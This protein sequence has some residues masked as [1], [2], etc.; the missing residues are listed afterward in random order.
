MK[1][2]LSHTL[3]KQVRDAGILRAGMR[4]G[5]AVSGGADSVGLLLLLRDLRTE[6]GLVLSAVHFNHKLRGNSSER[7]QQFVSALAEK[8]GITLHLGQAEVAAKAKFEKAN[9]EDAARRARYQ[10]FARLTSESIVDVVATAHSMDDQA[11]TVLAHIIRGTGIAGLA[12]IHPITDKVIRPLLGIRRADLRKYLRRKKQSWREDA[13]NRDVARNRARMRKKLLPLL[14]KQFNPAAVEHL[15]L[16]AGRALEHSRLVESLAEQLMQRCVRF[17]GTAAEV[18]VADLLN[19]LALGSREPSVL[20]ARLVAKIVEHVK[21]HRG[22]I[23][24]VHLEAVL[25]L[26]R[27]GENGK[28]IQLPAG[29]D[30]IKKHDALVFENRKT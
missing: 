21:Q 26:A 4:V 24:A 25:R 9:L 18:P 11:E 17:A 7:D 16:L 28:R 6:L 14:E 20:Q 8:L 27:T 15:A 23:L 19:P 30:A 1:N 2:A 22:Q 5:V 3:L 12:G 29:V 13:T 10:F